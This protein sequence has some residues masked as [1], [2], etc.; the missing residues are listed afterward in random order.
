MEWNANLILSVN[1][2]KYKNKTKIQPNLME[3]NFN[4]FCCCC[5]YKVI[6]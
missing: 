5:H 2:I 1:K 6:K 3:L 4:F